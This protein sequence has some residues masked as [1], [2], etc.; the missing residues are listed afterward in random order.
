MDHPSSRPD[1]TFLAAYNGTNILG[2]SEH[3]ACFDGGNF[4][5]G[6][7]VLNEPRYIKAGLDLVDGCAVI[8][9]GTPTKLGPEVF[10]WDRVGTNGT[11]T[12]DV[13]ANSTDFYQKEGFYIEW[14]GTGYGLGPEVGR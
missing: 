13:Y 2:Y 4:I 14:D 12:H 6:G 3:L 7:L 9:S 1:L 10:L 8:Y 11:R 5:L